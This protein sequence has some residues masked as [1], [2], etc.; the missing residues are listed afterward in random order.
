VHP[1]PIT[2]RAKTFDPQLQKKVKEEIQSLLDKRII[3]LSTSPYSAIIDVVYKKDGSIRVCV[4]PIKLNEATIDDGQPLPNMRELLDA[5][6][7]ASWYTSMDP[8]SGFWQIEIEEENK[9]K[10]AFRTSWGHY[11]Y[12]IMFCLLGSK[13]FQPP[14][15]A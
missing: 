13:M 9:H 5:L 2:T 10:T 15:N 8:A 12:C 6:G 4:A 3:R 14:F 1:F 7:G 11:E